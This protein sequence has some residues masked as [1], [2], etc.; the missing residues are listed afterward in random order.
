[1]LS[2]SLLFSLF[3]FLFPFLFN[4][5]SLLSSWL[6]TEMRTYLPLSVLCSLPPL[7]SQCKQCTGVSPAAWW[8]WCYS[9]CPSHHMERQSGTRTSAE[10]GRLVGTGSAGAVWQSGM[11]EGPGV[12]KTRAASAPKDALSWLSRLFFNSIPPSVLQV[13]TLRWEKCS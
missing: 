6:Q 7:R 12:W 9:G 11:M 1:M 3:S 8:D 10:L 4:C 2:S 13:C 5:I